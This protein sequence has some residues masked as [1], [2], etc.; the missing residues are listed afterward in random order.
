[1]SR[2]EAVKLIVLAQTLM[3][4]GLRVTVILNYP[5]L[6]A[7]AAVPGFSTITFSVLCVYYGE[8]NF[9]P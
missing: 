9:V 5:L 4:T 7:V 2:R 3:F 6:H 8:I 1:M